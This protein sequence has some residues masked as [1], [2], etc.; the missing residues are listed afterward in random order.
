[1]KV[2]AC[3]EANLA[4]NPLGLPSRALADF[5]G[6]PVLARVAERILAVGSVQEV[7][8][9]TRPDD[10]ARVRQ[11]LRDLPVRVHESAQPDV[12]QRKPLR[13]ARKWSRFG[14]RGGLHWTT[15]FDEH[16]WPKALHEA[17]VTS[18]ADSI[19]IVRA[20]APLL[21]PALTDAMVQHHLKYRKT[22]FFTFAQAPPGL[23]PEICTIDFLKTMTLTNETPLAVLRYKKEKPEMDRI[24]AECHFDCGETVRRMTWRLTADSAR[25]LA[26]LRGLWALAADPEKTGA[27]G[28]AALAGAH[29]EVWIGELPPFASVELVRQPAASPVPGRLL[30]EFMDPDVFTRIAEALAAGDDTCLTLEG[31]GDPLAHPRV[32]EIFSTLKTHR[33]YGVHLVTPGMLLDEKRADLLFA[34]DLDI[35]EIPLNAHTPETYQKLGGVGDFSGVS[36]NLEAFLARRKKQ[37]CV[38]PYLAVS[39]TKRLETEPEIEAFYETWLD[40]GAW[41]VI[42]PANRYAGQVPDSAPFPTNLAR[43]R[44]C[45]KI[46]NEL[47]LDTAGEILACREDLAARHPLAPPLP[48]AKTYDAGPLWREGKLAD[49]RT[50]HRRSAWAAFPLCPAC[51][52]W[53]RF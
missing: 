48:D 21:D 28:W 9:V 33:P 38:T 14:W 12:P 50:A 27:H 4:E 43:R 40:R 17:A 32:D 1:M 22:Y 26:A 42:R 34:A 23:V 24:R 19:A 39:I 52:E 35:L 49:L 46:Q 13:R 7:V 15:A 53:D 2:I 25:G 3:I 20:E 51:T 44:P 31:W 45:V 18:Q 10:A 8:V 5:C 29:P 37:G 41:P 36:A 47:Y 11:A 6:K 30:P 16:G